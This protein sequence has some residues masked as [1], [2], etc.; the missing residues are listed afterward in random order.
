MVDKICSG[1]ASKTKERC[2]GKE[3]KMKD[4]KEMKRGGR[5]ARERREIGVE[6]K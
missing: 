1:R 4:R 6:I 3:E 5:G 2:T